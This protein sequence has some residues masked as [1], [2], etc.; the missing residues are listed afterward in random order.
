M[1][2]LKS[3]RNYERLPLL[4]VPLLIN[5]PL[6]P[7]PRR[8][9][10]RKMKLLTDES[11]HINTFSRIITESEMEDANE[12]TNIIDSDEEIDEI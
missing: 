8:V 7:F 10:I 12:E 9:F 11:F 6:S 3:E 1:P 4:N 2:L 5:A